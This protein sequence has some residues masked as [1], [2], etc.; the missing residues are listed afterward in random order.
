MDS[1][2]IAQ[3]GYN[4]I[5]KACRASHAQDQED[6]AL[7]DDLAAQLPA[8]AKILDAGCGAGVPVARKLTCAGFEVVGVD[9]SEA[10]VRLARREVPSATFICQDMVQ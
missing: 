3:D 7:L 9:I 2:K 1:K 10:Q 8:G 6:V 5:A 4:T